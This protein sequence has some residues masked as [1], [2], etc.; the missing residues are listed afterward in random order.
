MEIIDVIVNFGEWCRYCKYRETATYEEPCNECLENSANKNS[1]RPV[2]F[3]KK[4]ES[5]MKK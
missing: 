3:A 2:K 1:E 5:I 4:S